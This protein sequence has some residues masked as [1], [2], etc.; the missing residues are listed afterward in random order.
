VGLKAP[1]AQVGARLPGGLEIKRAELRGVES[2]GM[3]C[4]ARELALADDASGLWELPE[5]APVGQA[6]AA[7]L[8]LP[9]A[10]IELKLTPNR[11]DCLSVN[12]VA[13]ELSTLFELPLS[14]S[15]QAAAPVTSGAR[16]QVQLAAPADCPRYLGRVIEGIDPA[17]R[18]PL[19]MAERLRRS[20][21]RPIGA[22]VDCANY[23]MLELGQPM[24]AFDHDRLEGEIV[25]R[26]AK[27]DEALVLLDGREVTL[28]PEFL[29]I[30]DARG[31]RA[32]A[33]IM[34]GNDSRVV[35]E[36]RNLF[37]ESAHFAPAV[38]LGRAR[39]L[40]MHTDASHRYERGVDPE[41][42]RIALERLTGLLLKI[43]GG[44]AGPVTEALAQEHLPR[45]RLVTLRHE[46]LQRVLGMTLAP[47]QVETILR[48]LD[49]KVAPVAGGW[50]VTPPAR[51]F[52]LELEEDLIEE[53]ARIHGYERVPAHAPGGELKLVPVPEGI[54][55]E[56]DFRRRLTARG[57][58]EA[59]NLS[60]VAP[61]L[62][63]AWGIGAG[64][65]AL[66][67]ALSADISVMR[68][69]LL[70][71]LVASLARNTSR[72]RERVRLFEVGV[73]FR[74][75]LDAPRET[76]R[77]AGVACGSA[78]AEQ[79]AIAARPLDFFDAK[80]DVE[81]LLTLN[82]DA[83]FGFAP[84]ARPY[85]HPG[86]AAELRRDGQVIGA[87]G[88]IHPG[89][90]NALDV[91]ADTHLF[92]F[93]LDPLAAR[94]VA[95]AGA[96]SRFPAIRRDLAVVLPRTVAFAEV[97]R[98]VRSAVGGR[99]RDLVLF[100]EYRGQGLSDTARSLAIGLI[101]QDESRTLTDEDATRDV[102]SAVAVLT[103]EFGARLRS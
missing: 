60:F 36:S 12:G 8:A 73:V 5:D 34:G 84:C 92:E 69:S 76:T 88:C 20:G 89:L 9:D 83:D 15:A 87:V 59:V 51:R 56:S 13:R 11:P 55:A 81:N 79:W 61:E 94:K 21:L 85:L 102:A 46:R 33:G 80:G 41:L 42:P 97:S 40:G 6:L 1:L 77:L 53:V 62:L 27:A 44:K 58:A 19:W 17:A 43:V 26:R 54:V 30:A 16:R 93:D 48:G 74:Q 68:T 49:L 99:L 67:N 75:D 18:T 91:P 95:R 7:Y 32:L 22:V 31:A 63:A 100:D 50:Q 25:V 23:V 10:T 14:S 64:A 39:K 72:Q 82:G 96:L 47:A 24:H 90:A 103:Q 28:T 38:I 35:D 98:A 66:A 101:L 57:Y 86:R 45:R 65:V 4:S 71:G 70:P 29:V 3:L 78:F 2:Q 37:L 52:D